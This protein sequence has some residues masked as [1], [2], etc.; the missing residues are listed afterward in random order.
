MRSKESVKLKT[1][2]AKKSMTGKKNKKQ[3]RWQVICDFEERRLA[4]EEKK[5]MMDL[6]ATENKTMIL[7]PTTRIPS[8][9]NGGI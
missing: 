4:L 6:V 8:L 2:E 9:S 1:S 3:A 5:S 7:D